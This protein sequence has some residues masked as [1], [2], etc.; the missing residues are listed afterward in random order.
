M[1]E[2]KEWGRERGGHTLV[3]SWRETKKNGASDF[4]GFF[5]LFE[6]Q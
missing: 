4:M 2:K 5:N 1:M 3:V 6:D